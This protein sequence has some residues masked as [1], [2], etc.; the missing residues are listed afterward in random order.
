[1]CL[2]TQKTAKLAEITATE[3]YK[4]RLTDEGSERTWQELNHGRPFLYL[5][6]LINSLYYGFF[7]Q[8]NKV[9]IQMCKRITYNY[10]M[11]NIPE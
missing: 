6:L 9:Q 4:E 1:M 11:E 2:K 7:K 10:N 8:E 5:Y 3:L